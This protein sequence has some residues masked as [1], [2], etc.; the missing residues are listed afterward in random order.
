MF[1]VKN[2][3][4]TALF[5]FVLSF[6]ISIFSTHRLFT[7]LFRGIVF[8]LVFA[9]I[10]FLFDF[11]N[12]KFLEVDTSSFDSS[13]APKAQAQK[14]GTRVN[15]VIEDEPL[16][17]DES[18]PAFNVSSSVRG[19]VSY[20]NASVQMGNSSAPASSSV[21]AVSQIA[22]ENAVSSDNDNSSAASSA[23]AGIRGSSASGTAPVQTAP[24]EGSATAGDSF[25]P[26]SLGTPIKKNETVKNDVSP[27]D[28]GGKAP[29]NS[30]LEDLP[31]IGEFQ[32]A[33]SSRSGSSGQEVEVIRDSD[34]AQEGETMHTASAMTEGIESVNQNSKTIASAIRTLL[35][36]DE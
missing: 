15:Y 6:L 2:I 30:E 29:A 33:E 18:A 22:M 14:S 26:V 21:D 19:P 20:G 25:K 9:I 32:D 13:P 7:S 3:V 36:S 24:K 16:T 27:A 4:F 5:G 23:A 1:K 8:L 31:D 35:K 12:S 17:E 11:L 28:S 10:G 34:F